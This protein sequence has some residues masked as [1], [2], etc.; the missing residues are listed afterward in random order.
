MSG[1]TRQ[2]T[3]AGDREASVA[4]RAMSPGPIVAAHRRSCGC[5]IIDFL[6]N[7]DAFGRSSTPDATA[8]TIPR[9]ALAAHRMLELLFVYYIMTTLGARIYTYMGWQLASPIA[10]DRCYILLGM[11]AITAFRQAHW[12]LTYPGAVTWFIVA[13]TFIYTV[14][15]SM[16]MLIGMS[17]S[18]P[19]FGA[20]HVIKDIIGV[21]LFAVGSFLE[22]YSER[23]RA[24]FKADPANRGKMF[25]GGLFRYARHINYTGHLLYEVGQGLFAGSIACAI[26]LWIFHHLDFAIRSIPLLHTYMADRYRAQYTAYCA[27]TPYKL[28][29]GIVGL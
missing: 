2:R 6:L 27:Q 15:N 25:T 16:C 11:M 28:I 29:P 10:Y 8:W 22:Y 9:V 12:G 4:E 14:V 20:P 23:Q 24:E 13:I 19:A 18:T 1:E 17:H 21:V 26:G 5:G 3:A 7:L